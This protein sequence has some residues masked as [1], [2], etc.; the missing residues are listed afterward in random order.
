MNPL[1]EELRELAAAAPE[2]EW[3]AGRAERVDLVSQKVDALGMRGSLRPRDGIAIVDD[4][5][6]FADFICQDAPHELQGKRPTG[7]IVDELHARPF[8][9]GLLCVTPI[10]RNR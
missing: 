5:K 10:S 1:D 8:A 7:V 6:K 4:R 9:P 3:R 2:R